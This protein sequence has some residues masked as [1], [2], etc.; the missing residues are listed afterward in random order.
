MQIIFQNLGH[1]EAAN[2]SSDGAGATL[3][4]GTRLH[5][6]PGPPVTRG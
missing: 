4:S 6:G 2:V 1:R 5:G 3:A